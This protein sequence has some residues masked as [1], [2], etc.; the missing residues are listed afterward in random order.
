[1]D[2]ALKTLVLIIFILVPG[3]L[4][5]RVYFQ[6][7][8]SQQFDSKSWSHSIFYSA[9]FGILINF[10][11]FYCYEYLFQKINYPY[12]L[13]FYNSLTK[14]EIKKKDL[15]LFSIESVYKYL[16]ILYFLSIFLGW[17]IYEVVRNFKLDRYFGPLRFSNNWHYYFKGEIKDFKDFS[18]EKGKCNAT[19]VDVLVKSEKDGNNL[20]SGI[21]TSYDLDHNGNLDYIVLTETQIYNQTQ[22]KF[23]DIHSTVFKIPNSNINNINFRYSYL[24]EDTTTIDFISV[25]LLFSLWF[26]TWWDPS[27][28]LFDYNLPSKIVLKLFICF[29][30][31]GISVT[32]SSILRLL[33]YNKILKPVTEDMNPKEKSQIEKSNSEKLLKIKTMKN[34]IRGSFYSTLTFVI[35]CVAIIYF[36]Y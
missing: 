32:I 14:E 5:R 20:Y 16:A 28:I 15:N 7:P 1:M 6:G 33:I 13:S 27:S 3:F 35:A 31:I 18:L 24:D 26:Y 11:G 30:I 17:F 19:T 29:T 34:D 22:K 2:I 36:T 10:I 12:C 8:F 23:R 25:V 9:L 21:L 4:F